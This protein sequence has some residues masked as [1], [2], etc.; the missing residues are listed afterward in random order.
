MGGQRFDNSEEKRNYSLEKNEFTSFKAQDRT[1]IF[2]SQDKKEKKEN[3]PKKGIYL[4]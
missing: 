1:T 3:V 4:Q 2:K